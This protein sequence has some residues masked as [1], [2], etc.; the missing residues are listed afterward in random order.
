[1]RQIAAR[2]ALRD[3]LERVFIRHVLTHSEYN[4]EKWKS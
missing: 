3:L 1:M 4:K 2:L